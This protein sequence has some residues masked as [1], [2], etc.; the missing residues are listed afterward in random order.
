MPRS[1]SSIPLSGFAFAAPTPP[2]ISQFGA[3]TGRLLQARTPAHCQAGAAL[4]GMHTG[5]TGARVLTDSWTPHPDTP[6]RG[7]LRVRVFGD[8]SI[9]LGRACPEGTAWHPYVFS[10]TNPARRLYRQR[11]DASAI[12]ELRWKPGAVT[13]TLIPTP[14]TPA[15]LARVWP[16]AVEEALRAWDEA[17]GAPRPVCA[18][19]SP[20]GLFSPAA[21]FAGPSPAER[22]ALSALLQALLIWAAPAQEARITITPHQAHEGGQAKGGIISISG[23]PSP[24]ATAILRWLGKAAHHPLWP[25]SPGA[26]LAAHPIT[27]LSGHRK[28]P[29]LQ[30]LAQEASGPTSA[31]V[32]VRA[33]ATL[34]AFAIPLEENTP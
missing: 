23:L 24:K 28:P 17:L 27:P 22:Q 34:A 1:A 16:A 29:P 8:A 7:A 14:D 25:L 5:W 2:A 6:K 10:A 15:P 20:H 31:H 9:L 30:P 12:P 4:A 3:F 26:S 21:P 13:N 32:R 18:P 19:D 33:S 11:S